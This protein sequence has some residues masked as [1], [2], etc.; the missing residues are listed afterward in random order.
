LIQRLQP[1]DQ[2]L[3]VEAIWDCCL[4]DVKQIECVDGTVIL[5]VSDSDDL[6]Y[7]KRRASEQ[8]G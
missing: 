1:F 5:D 6:E 7:H 8:L 3:P 2:G 4:W